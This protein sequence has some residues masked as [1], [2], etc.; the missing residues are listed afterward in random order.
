MRQRLDCEPSGITSGENASDSV[1]A[2]CDARLRVDVIRYAFIVADL[3]S[4][5]LAPIEVVLEPKALAKQFVTGPSVGK[6]FRAALIRSKWRNAAVILDS[7]IF[8]A[9]VRS[10]QLPVRLGSRQA[11][12]NGSR[13]TLGA[14]S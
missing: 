3:R 13:Q 9:A 5:C 1:P 6:L 12:S 4:T 14:T 11:R 7:K 10:V 8:H 2:T